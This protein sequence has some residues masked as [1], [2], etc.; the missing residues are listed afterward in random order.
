[1]SL[2]KYTLIGGSLLFLTLGAMNACTENGK[3]SENPA[4]EMY[5]KKL[6]SMAASTLK[7]IGA[8]IDTVTTLENDDIDVLLANGV[9]ICF[10]SEG[11]WNKV[12]MHKNDMTDD[13]LSLLPVQTQ[14]YLKENANGKSIKRFDRSRKKRLTVT[15]SGKE[16]L[17]FARN[18]KFMP[19]DVKKLPS[20]VTALLNKYFADDAITTATVDPNYEYSVDLQS[21]IY[22]EFDR[23]GH[24]ERVETPKGHTIPANFA[25]YFPSLM[26]KYMN[27]NY[28]DKVIRR[29]IRKDY[30]YMVKTEKPDA[31]ELCFSKTGD[32]LRLANKGEENEE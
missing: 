13:I 18:G 32:Y 26:M 14:T 31:V 25:N 10:D 7:K 24:F 22:L 30:G 17:N 3:Q 11:E 16:E 8:E 6:P 15:L 21:G 20:Q 27:K 23:M 28:P 4:Q 5:L 12:N 29:I 2:S 1:M 19:N 9:E